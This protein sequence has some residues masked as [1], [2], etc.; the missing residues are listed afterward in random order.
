MSL[1]KE[2]WTATGVDA[3][4][5]SCRMLLVLLSYLFISH[6]DKLND[7]YAAIL[8]PAINYKRIAGIIITH[9]AIGSSI[10]MLVTEMLAL[11]PKTIC[12]IALFFAYLACVSVLLRN[13]ILIGLIRI[14]Q[15]RA[16]GEI[17]AKCVMTPRCS[18]YMAGAIKKY[19]VYEGVSRGI[20]RLRRCGPP[21][22]ND[23]P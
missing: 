7:E 13:K 17:R 2:T 22:R 23:Y 14:Y 4:M 18:D 12:I 8:R 6:E 20:E 5:P 15:A 11:L 19:G 3:D 10:G 16:P 21:A 9:I 1:D